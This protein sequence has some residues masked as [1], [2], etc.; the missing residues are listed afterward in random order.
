MNTIAALKL[1]ALDMLKS[2]AAEHKM[3]MDEDIVAFQVPWAMFHELQSHPK[4]QQSAFSFMGYID[5]YTFLAR[6]A[7]EISMFEKGSTFPWNVMGG[8]E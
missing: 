4:W 3:L 2:A 7:C 5:S 6:N 8:E 1:T